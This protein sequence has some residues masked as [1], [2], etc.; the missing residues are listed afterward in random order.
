M[1]ESRTNHIDDIVSRLS[2]LDP[3]RIVLFASHAWGTAESESDI[4]LLVILDS[5]IISQTYHERMQKRLTLRKSL[6]AINRHLPI[7]PIVYAKGENE[8]L[9][10]HGSSF[11]K[12][13][14]SSGKK[15]PAKAGSSAVGFKQS[16]LHDTL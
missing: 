15:L 14:E 12:E 3:Y 2:T 7:D 11:L 5:A 1:V 16:R 10:R 9:R 6:Q 8:L 4:D 13:I